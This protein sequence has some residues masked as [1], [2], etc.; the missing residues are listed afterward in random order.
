MAAAT[1]SNV[2]PAADVPADAPAAEYEALQ[3]TD[4]VIANL[5]DLEL[6]HIE[7]F[8]FDEEDS[9]DV[10]KR[11]PTCKTYPGDAL[12][13]S[14]SVWKVF[15]LLTGGSLIKTVPYGSACY[16]GQHYDAEKCQFLLDNWNQSTTQ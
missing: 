13:P 16:E 4:D 8:A 11:A 15:D 9:S 1:E 7:L 12:Y 6:S 2:L 3:L 10:E 14:K 5:T